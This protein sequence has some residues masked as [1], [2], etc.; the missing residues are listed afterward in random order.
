M[1]WTEP[2]PSD[3]LDLMK[4][5]ILQIKHVLE[6]RQPAGW[7]KRWLDVLKHKHVPVEGHS[8]GRLEMPP[9]GLG[10]P[11]SYGIIETIVRTMI[12]SGAVRHGSECFNFWFPQALDERYLV[13]WEGFEVQSVPEHLGAFKPHKPVPWRYMTEPELRAFLLARIADGYAFPLSPKWVLCDPGWRE[14]FEAQLRAEPLRE[15]LDLWYPKELHL[16]ELILRIC[17]DHPDGFVPLANPDG[18]PVEEF[19]F[20]IAEWHIRREEVL[21]RAKAKL[22][23]FVR[24]TGAVA[25][26]RRQ[27]LVAAAAAADASAQQQSPAGGGGGDT[28]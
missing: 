28:W 11:R 2:L 18:A 15:A 24:L 21:R 25:A 17:D 14:I 5:M 4:W 9:Y 16:R 23:G 8:Y 6:E 27:A 22:Q 20:D 19:D 7:N 13:V 26:R 12:K 10:D 1:R 3:Q